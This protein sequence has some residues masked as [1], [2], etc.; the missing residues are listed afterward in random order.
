MASTPDVARRGAAPAN[1]CGPVRHSRRERWRMLTWALVHLV[2][3]AHLVQWWRS[4]STLTPIEPSEAMQTLEQGYLNAGFLFFGIAIAATAVFGRFFCGWGCHLVAYQDMAGALLR[5]VGWKPRPFRSRLLVYVPIGAAFYMFIWPQIARLAE[6]RPFPTIVYHLTTSD[7]W[8]TFPSIG[9]SLLTF[10]VCGGLIVFL[11]GNKGFCTY[12]CPYGAFFGQADR[13]AFGQILV[14]DACTGC[15]H[16]TATCTSNVRVHEEVRVH[17]KVVDTGCMKC[18][19]CVDVCPKGALSYG[20]SVP[21]LFQRTRGRDTS[22]EKRTHAKAGKTSPIRYDFTWPQEIALGLLFL[23]CLYA[24]RGL[25][26]AIPFLLSLG[27]AAVTSFVLLFAF[28]GWRQGGVVLQRLTLRSAGR[29]T[30]AGW[31]FQA[32]TALLL[33]FVAHSVWIQF[34]AHQAEA[35]VARAQAAPDDA[36]YRREAGEAARHYQRTLDHGLFEVAAW[37]LGLGSSQASI[38]QWSESEQNL[39]R[40]LEL[41]PELAR[42]H[43]SLADVLARTDRREEGLQHLADAARLDPEVAALTFADAALQVGTDGDCQVALD[44]LN[45]WQAHAP[46]LPARRVAQIEA[47]RAALRR[48]IAA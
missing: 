48:R 4:G 31:M 39:R 44:A 11:L 10:V 24:Y 18:M 45:A 8:E 5:R 34:H 30:P 12:A 21:S 41:D 36:A 19:D 37:R 43:V 13:L 23:F 46:H 28:R 22:K 17:K 9:I 40:A 20:F 27:L 25:Y 35:H 32:V 15:G 38:G 16:C 14:S 26:E 33:T 2:F 6:G 42:A 47:A 29:W 1:D 3:V 7:L